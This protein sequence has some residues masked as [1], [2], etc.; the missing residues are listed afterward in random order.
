MA[1]GTSAAMFRL[2]ENWTQSSPA[3]LGQSAIAALPKA[4]TTQSKTALLVLAQPK[5]VTAQSKAATALPKALT[6]QSIATLATPI[7]GQ[8]GAIPGGITGGVPG[9][10][11][12][13][14]TVGVS[15]GMTGGQPSDMTGG[16]TVGEMDKPISAADIEVAAVSFKDFYA[17]HRD[18]LA[19]ALGLYFG[20]EDL[21]NEAADEAFTRAF[22]RW[23]SVSQHP[24]PYG[25]VYVVG[26][27]RARS[28]LRR[29][30]VARNKRQLLEDGSTPV[31]ATSDAAGESSD[32]DTKAAIARLRP[33]L[34]SVVIARFYLEMSVEEAAEVLNVRPG[35]VKSRL[36]RALDQL[37]TDLDQDS[38]LG[39]DNAPGY[40]ETAK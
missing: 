8:P 4:A 9:G 18:K 15:G 16:V 27:N 35:T 22:E 6:T 34:R 7:S 38:A 33:A 29:Q 3:R 31:Y 23:Q 40:G 13:G 19:R 1:K 17:T 12:G 26:T 37:R 2:Q 21:G 28:V 5:A 25:W 20:N 24:N 30:V 14:V 36:S 32:L 11:I 10:V 39:H